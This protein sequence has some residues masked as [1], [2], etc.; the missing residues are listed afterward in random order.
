M[1]ELPVTG[2]VSEFIGVAAYMRRDSLN[3]FLREGDSVTGAYLAADMRYAPEIF[4]R[5]K[6]IPAVAGTTARSQ[7]LAA[8]YDTLAK[9]MLTFAFVNTILACSIAIGVIYNTV[10]IAMGERSRELAS[11]RVLGYTRGEVSYILLG[12]IALLVL[13]SGTWLTI[14]SNKGARSAL[15]LD[16]S[17]VARPFLPDA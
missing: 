15:G 11:L 12:E 1:R 3:R 16:K 13:A 6:K 9:Q 10:R 14:R 17:M 2:V 5:L 4:A 8:F 7:M